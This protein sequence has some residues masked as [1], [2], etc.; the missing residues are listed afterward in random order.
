LILIL[1]VTHIYFLIYLNLDEKTNSSKHREI[2]NQSKNLLKKFNS[3]ID[4]TEKPMSHL[5]VVVTSNKDEDD[6]S[7][8]TVEKNVP[9]KTSSNSRKKWGEDNNNNNNHNLKSKKSDSVP[10]WKKL[11]PIPVRPFVKPPAINK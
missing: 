8:I 11:E 6:I 9:G 10:I 5:N 1:R 7:C 2:L 3:S 4:S